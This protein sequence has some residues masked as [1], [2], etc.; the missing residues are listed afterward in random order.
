MKK[1]EFKVMAWLRMI[2]E[3]QA[4]DL[5]GKGVEERV[6]YYRHQAQELHH[7]L[8]KQKMVTM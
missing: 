5:K 3:K 2:R 8:E 1:I 7:K 4:A 6:A